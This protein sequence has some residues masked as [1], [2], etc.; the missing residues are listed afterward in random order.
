MYVNWRLN[1]STGLVDG[2]KGW[3]NSVWQC[4]ISFHAELLTSTGSSLM[5][6]YKRLKVFSLD[7]R[8]PRHVRGWKSL[9]A[10]LYIG[11]KYR[12]QYFIGCVLSFSSTCHPWFI[13]IYLYHMR[14]SIL[15]LP[16]TR[17]HLNTSIS[18][19]ISAW[20]RK[21]KCD[22]HWKIISHDSC[23]HG[24]V[25]EN[26]RGWNCLCFLYQIYFQYLLHLVI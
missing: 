11:V 8:H 12:F 21:N 19:K 5:C 24:W 10:L 6:R 18:W 16:P 20:M 9:K 4:F 25:F 13:A 22:F 1:P 15:H 17:T 2:T 14:F 26:S 23:F 7:S 3:G